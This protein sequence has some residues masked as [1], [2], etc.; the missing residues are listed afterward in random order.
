M[1]DPTI[2]PA[3]DPILAL[4]CAIHAVLI[5]DAELVALL[6]GPR[7]HDPVPRGASGVYVAYG[8]ARVRDRSG[9]DAAIH[10]HDLTLTVWSRPGGPAP[11][12]AVAARI[13][14]LLDDASL[15]LD[16]HRLVLLRLA[17]EEVKRDE[18]A[19]LS[20]VLMRFSALTERL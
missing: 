8:D 1:T 20:R 14:A 9:D 16:G 13:A 5:A 12:L 4:R 15:V 17:S 2:D 11:A 7:I 3:T 19:D 6:G 18:R 10:E